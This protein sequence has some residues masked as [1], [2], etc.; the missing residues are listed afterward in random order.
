VSWRVAAFASRFGGDLGMRSGHAMERLEMQT[1]K[2]LHAIAACFS[3]ATGR[4][5]TDH[6]LREGRLICQYRIA[7]T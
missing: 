2:S 4:T 3:E 1:G 5:V 7:K 6:C